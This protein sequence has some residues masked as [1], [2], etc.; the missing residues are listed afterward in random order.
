MPKLDPEIREQIDYYLHQ[1]HITNEHAKVLKAYFKYR[2]Q[3]EAADALNINVSSFGGYMHSLTQRNILIKVGKGKFVINNDE[4]QIIPVV[5]RKIDIQPI[6][7][8]EMSESERKWMLENYVRYRDKRSEAAR[9]LGRSKLD[10]CRMAIELGIDQKGK[11]G[12]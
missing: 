7:D 4:S 9:I 12:N 8:L 11:G 5:S 3:K 10:V 1:M 2:N 6:P